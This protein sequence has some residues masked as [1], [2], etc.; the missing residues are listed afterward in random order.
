[1]T[2]KFAISKNFLESRIALAP[3]D[4]S[5]AL[6]FNAEG[7]LL[8]Q[9]RDDKSEIFFPHH[10]GCFGGACDPGESRE[11]TLLRE[12]QEEL[13]LDV[14]ALTITP[15]TT[16]TYLAHPTDTTTV[17]RYYYALTLPEPMLKSL[18]LGEGQEARFFTTAEAHALP[19]MLP[20]DK[21]AFW[22]YGNEKRLIK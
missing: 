14:S 12:L 22:L 10:W 6:I 17:A 1:M 11:Q 13:G 4:S 16:I 18:K 21:F 3:K 5:A 9:L 20:Y 15:A 2:D 19:N 7:K 8:L